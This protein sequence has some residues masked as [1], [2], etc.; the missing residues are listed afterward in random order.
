[1]F[2]GLLSALAKV[3]ALIP[4]L[5]HTQILTWVLH[6]DH[7]H[8]ACA[9]GPGNGKDAICGTGFG[10]TGDAGSEHQERRAGFWLLSQAV[11]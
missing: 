5:S 7:P 4:H 10:L 6:L 8:A 2:Y 9:S 3:H 1:M 11:F